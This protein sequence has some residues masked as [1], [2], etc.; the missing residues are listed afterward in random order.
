MRKGYG[1]FHVYDYHFDGW[2]IEGTDFGKF[3]IKSKKQ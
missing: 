2:K 1:V 3:V